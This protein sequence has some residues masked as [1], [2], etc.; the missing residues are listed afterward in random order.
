[1]TGEQAGSLETAEEGPVVP[2]LVASSLP[3][4]KLPVEAGYGQ[5]K[6]FSVN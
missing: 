2:A 3:F 6:L 5:G 4:C 1:M